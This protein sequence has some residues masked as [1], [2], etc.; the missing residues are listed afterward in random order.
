M[1]SSKEKHAII[2]MCL[3]AFISIEIISFI[4]ISFINKKIFS[5]RRHIKEIKT[6]ISTNTFTDTEEKK[7]IYGDV[8]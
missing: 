2:G 5:Y 6:V 4:A 1:K 3:L 7:R 8:G